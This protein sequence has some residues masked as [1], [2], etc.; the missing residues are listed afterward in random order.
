VGHP[1]SRRR[2]SLDAARKSGTLSPSIV[3]SRAFSGACGVIARELTTV[4][5][6]RTLCALVA[7]SEGFAINDV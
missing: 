4:S 5:S 6:A 2:G 3:E 1:A 7:S